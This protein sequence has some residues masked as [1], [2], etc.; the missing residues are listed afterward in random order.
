MDYERFDKAIILKGIISIM[1]LF[2]LCSRAGIF[3]WMLGRQEEG[4]GFTHRFVRE[5]TGMSLRGLIWTA[6]QGYALQQ[7]GFG[8]QYSLSGSLMSILYYTAEKMHGFKDNRQLDELFDGPEF[9]WG[10]FVWLVLI[11]SCV[12]QLVYRIRQWVHHRSKDSVRDPNG[13]YQVFLY[14]SLNRMV[15]NFSYNVLFVVFWIVL[16]ASTVFYSLI[17]QTDLKNKGQTFYGL[18]M[19]ILALTV[20]MCWNWSASFTRW[21]S[22]KEKRKL[23]KSQSSTPS[24]I[25][26]LEQRGMPGLYEP[27]ETDRLLPY[28]WPYSHPDKGFGES[29]PRIDNPSPIGFSS[30]SPTTQRNYLSHHHNHA[31]HV[32]PL[33][34]THRLLIKTWLAIDKWVYMDI[35]VLIRHAIGVLSI[36]SLLCTISFCCYTILL[37]M[38][39][40]VFDPQYYVCINESIWNQSVVIP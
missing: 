29:R 23:K 34:H 21:S 30:N 32:S 25:N 15:L 39:G 28:N 14:Q 13:S 12:S 33:S 19:S 27:S 26:Y 36:A 24:R 40:P 2:Y 8:W 18:F 1:T 3:D 10:M 11:A 31:P 6:P 17:I 4:W 35:F 38:G 7:L 37:D 22:E 20:F 16:S 5:Y 9:Y